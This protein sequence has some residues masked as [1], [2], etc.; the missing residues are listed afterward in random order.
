MKAAATVADINKYVVYKNVAVKAGEFTT[1][2]ATNLDLYVG[3][4]TVVLRNNFKFAYTF[5]EGKTYDV[6]AVVSYFKTDKIVQL[7]FVSAVASAPQPKFYVTGDSALVADAGAPGK[8][9]A[10]DAIPSMEDTLTLN[11]KANQYYVLKVVDGAKWYGYN[12]LTEKT[13]G[14]IDDNAE[15]HNIGFTLAEAGAVKVIYKAGDPILLK[16]EG[17]FV[18]PAPAVPTVAAPVPTYPAKQVKSLYSDAY[19]FAPESLN[20]YNEGW[21]DNPTMK[22]EEISGDKYL[23]Y[24]GRMTG[25]IGWQFGEIN[26]SNME[27]IHIDVWPSADA[28]F[29]MGPTTQNKAGGDNYVA[30]VALTVEAGKWNSID[31]PVADL[32]AANPNFSL[33]SVFQ[34]QFTGYSALTD[35]S[36]DNIF[37]YTT[38]AP[39]ADT[40]APTAFTAVMDAASFFSVNIKANATDNSGAVEFDVLN[41]ELIIASAKAV[42]ATDRIITVGGLTPNTEYNFSVIAKDE[43]GNATAPIAVAAKTLAAPAPAPA[44]T[45]AADDVKSIYSDAYDFAPDTLN[46][47][48]EGWWNAPVMVEGQL[49]EGDNALFYAAATTGMIG[50]QFGEMDLTAYAELH[51]DIYPIADGSILIYP[52]NNTDPKGEYKDTY[53]VKGGQWNSL[54]IDLSGK[55]LTKIFQIAWIDYY[56]LNGFFIDNVYFAKKAEPV[57]APYYLVGTM[58]EWKPAEAYQFV[59]NPATAGEYMLETTLTVG[60]KF[61]VAKSENGETIAD[62]DWYPGGMGNDYVVD[63]AHAGAVTIY[64]RPDGQGGEGWYEGYFYVSAGE[65]FENLF[66][67]GKAVK[68]LHNG[69]IYIL[70]NNKVYTVMGQPVE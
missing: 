2:S 23:H 5:E 34:N 39:A 28:T 56:A 41:G 16:V 15:Y 38:V 52:V 36:I 67:E 48:N 30:T 49:A 29:N 7:Y 33:A 11:L 35:L 37:F 58:T 9:W 53:N 32:L 3:N 22:E 42:S 57:A 40:V 18:L 19:D 45:A 61:K 8:V 55:D 65:G 51:I 27:Y 10:A 31:I 12:E 70:K 43:D 68:V 64:F 1:A 54:V 4:D 24:N 17:N 6:T 20:S 13:A 60:D 66:V 21:W 46:S 14:L 50:W 62:S 44:P 47:Y 59:A 26:V 69:Q 25:M 63:A